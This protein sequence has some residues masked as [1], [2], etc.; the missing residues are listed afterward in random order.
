MRLQ[1][2]G[3]VVTARAYAAAFPRAIREPLIAVVSRKL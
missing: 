2:T 1:G 3:A